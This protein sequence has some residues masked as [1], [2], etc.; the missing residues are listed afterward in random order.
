MSLSSNTPGGSA[1]QQIIVRGKRVSQDSRGYISLDDLWE[2]SGERATRKPVP[3][4]NTPSAKALARALDDK[5]RKSDIN[6]FLPIYSRRGRGQ[7]GTYAHPIMAA[8]YAGYLDPDLEIEVREVWLRY[9]GGDATLA[10]EIL[11]RA[12][13]EA[14][15]WAGVRALARSGRNKFTDVLRRMA[16]SA[17]RA[18]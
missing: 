8:A 16:C 14:N 18:I 5:I 4:K 10:D 15:H 12:T 2:L 13:D 11:Q 6:A 3:W 7:K 9:R 17:R 1:G